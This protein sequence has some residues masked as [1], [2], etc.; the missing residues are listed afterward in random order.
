MPTLLPLM[1]LPLLLLISPLMRLLLQLQFSHGF[2][3]KRTQLVFHMRAS[4]DPEGEDEE[5]CATHPA[6]VCQGSWQAQHLQGS[7]RDTGTGS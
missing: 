7:K 5:E 6:K 2:G 3:K 4:P 1:L